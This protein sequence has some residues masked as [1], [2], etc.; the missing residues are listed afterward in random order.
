V[1]FAEWDQEIQ[2]FPPNSA[3]QA[4]TKCVRLGCSSRSLQNTN[5]ETLQCRVQARGEDSIPVVDDEVVGMIVHEELPELLGGP[6][7][8]RVLSDVAV[9]DTA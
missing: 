9:Q 6:L 7:G 4:F 2:A 1:T 5:A 3:D 8:G